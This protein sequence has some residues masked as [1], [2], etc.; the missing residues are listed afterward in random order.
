MEHPSAWLNADDASLLRARAHEAE[1][2]GSLHPEQLAIIFRNNWLRMFVPI[3][4]GGLGLTLPESLRIEEGLA[5]ADGSAAW[6]VTLCSGAAWFVGFLHPEVS[7]VIFRDDHVCL[8]G[9]GAVT[10]VAEITDS[11]YVIQGR[12]KYASGSL[13]ATA[14]TMNC[15]VTKNG[16]PVLRADGSS[17]IASFILNKNDVTIQRTWKSMGMIATG[18]H[19]FE[20]NRVLVPKDRCFIISPDRAVL[21][22][23]IY[24]YPFLQLA[25]TT[26]AVNLSGMAMRFIELAGSRLAET[27]SS[28]VAM[29]RTS[30][31]ECRSRFFEVADR[32]WQRLEARGSVPKELLSEVSNVSH[33]LVHHARESINLLYPLC[34]LSAAATDQEINRVWRNFHTA[35]Q[36]A[37]FNQLTTRS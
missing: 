1:A 16:Q 17:E 33:Q 20:V 37:L 29:S 27:A 15:Q 25:E 18:S 32:S 4:L 35:G 11:A 5:W 7:A 8:A 14:F 34:G 23:F 3:D 21:T 22:S 9:S 31:D 19:S 6:V 13:H 36:H 12:W 24:R 26:L 10:G 28:E 2:L 30:L